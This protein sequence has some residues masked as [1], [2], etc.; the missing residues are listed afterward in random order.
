[1]YI[2]G[3]IGNSETKVYLV[4]SNNQILKD[5]NF[6][7]KDINKRILKSYLKSKLNILSPK[8]INIGVNYKF[9]VISKPNWGGSSR[10]ISFIND[11]KSLKM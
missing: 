2:L 9:P 6:L 4:N 1:M 7:S 8:E 11:Y 10:G 5:I 3:D